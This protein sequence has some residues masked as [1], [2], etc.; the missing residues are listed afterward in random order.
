MWQ[1]RRSDNA[2]YS[3]AWSWKRIFYFLSIWIT[4]IGLL[5]TLV[6]AL[7]NFEKS[8]TVT[9]HMD[10]SDSY[11]LILSVFVLFHSVVWSLCVYTKSLPQN[12]YLNLVLDVLICFIIVAWIGLTTYLKDSTHFVFV[13]IFIAS[14]F[15]ALALITFLTQDSLSRN[16]MYL[17]LIGLFI[18]GIFMII[19]RSDDRF[20][21]P[22]YSAF[23]IYAAV[24][25]LYFTMHPY[26]DW[27]QNEDLKA[28]NCLED[29]DSSCYNVTDDTQSSIPL[30]VVHNPHYPPNKTFTHIYRVQPSCI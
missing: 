17:G 18:C 21:L 11:R 5:G 4:G 22:E 20:W 28:N 30:L 10:T 24:F 9:E 27:A 15:L 2:D 14:V 1:P 25:T 23:I 3:P 7:V 8:T 19:Y 26:Y 13:I 12:F 6:Y 16:I 29:L